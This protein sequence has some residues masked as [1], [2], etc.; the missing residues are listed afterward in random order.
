[1]T[2]CRPLRTLIVFGMACV[3]TLSA[4]GAQDPA[5]RKPQIVLTAR[6]VLAFTPARI[7]FSAD[8]RG[9]ADD[10]ED[11]YCAE[12]EWDWDDGTS[13]QHAGD[14]DPYRPGKSEIKR[15]FTAE[16]TYDV[17]NAYRPAFRLKKRN[18]VVGQARADVE[19]RPGRP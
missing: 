5:D 14:C 13:S 3:G 2:F 12:V 17:A 7:K 18:K 8:L 9:G 6:P 11:F 15:H 4:G 10:Y 19:V 16:H 1:M